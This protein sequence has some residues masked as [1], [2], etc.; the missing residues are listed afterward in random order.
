MFPRLQTEMLDLSHVV[1]ASGTRYISADGTVVVSDTSPK[2]LHSLASLFDGSNSAGVTGCSSGSVETCYWVAADNAERATFQV[3]FSEPKRLA[4]IRTRPVGSA[5]HFANLAVQVW[6]LDSGWVTPSEE[7]ESADVSEPE[8]GAKME[9]QTNVWTDYVKF[10]LTRGGCEECVLAMDEIEFHLDTAT[11][12]SMPTPFS[13]TPADGDP[14]VSST[15]ETTDGTIVTASSNAALAKLFDGSGVG[16]VWDRTS[17]WKG[18]TIDIDFGEARSLSYVSIL[19]GSTGSDFRV[20]VRGVA[21]NEFVDVSGGFVTG[22]PH[23]SHVRN[24]VSNVRIE[25]K[26][27]TSGGSVALSD[28]QFWP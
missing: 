27:S 13:M 22:W 15:Y 6:D 3:T 5:H 11:G 12:W 21:E 8:V 1:S 24:E 18:V 2:E 16:A 28:I 7:S 17:L 19:P 9:F 4:F 23:K 25:V 14:G 10:D 20:E 26:P